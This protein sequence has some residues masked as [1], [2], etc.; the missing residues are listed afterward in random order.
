MRSDRLGEPRTVARCP[1]R[2][3]T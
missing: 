1:R 2:T 3:T